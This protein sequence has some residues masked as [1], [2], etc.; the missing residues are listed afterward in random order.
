MRA[1]HPAAWLVHGCLFLVQKMQE[2]TM[3]LLGPQPIRGHAELGREFLEMEPKKPKGGA[4]FFGAE[5]TMKNNQATAERTDQPRAGLASWSFV[6]LAFAHFFAVLNDNTYRWLVTPLGYHLL[7]P[8]YRPLIL[9]LG[10]ACF[11]VSYI[12][13]VAPS[14]YLADRFSKRTV[15]AWCMTCEAAILIFG[16]VSILMSSA[17]LVF[18]ALTLM[19]AAG[20][21]MAPAF[22]GAI[23]ETVQEE[24]ISAANGALGLAN[25]LA[26]VV[27]SV[28]GN[29]LYVLA[30]PHGDSWW[31]IPGGV[32]LGFTALGWA[33]ALLVDRQP[34]ADPERGF[35]KRVFAQ[36][37]RDLK[38]LAGRRALFG[39]AAASAFLWFL[40]ATAQVNVYLFATTT[41]DI[42]QAAVGPLLGVLAIG[43]AMGSVLAAVW[44]GHRIELGL[45]PIGAGGIMVSALVLFFTPRVAAGN[46]SFAYYWSCGG[47]FLMGM[48]AGLYD[49]PLRAYLQE[50]SR[51]T[52]RGEILGAGNFLIFTAMLVA[53]GLFFVLTQLMA[54]GA[55]M[56]F[57]IAGIITVAATILIL[58]FLHRQAAE[59][60][61]KPLRRLQSL[62]GRRNF[63]REL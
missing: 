20:A 40:A 1:A 21:L 44:S 29:F 42:S 25:V 47:L 57:L 46:S 41:L 15:I 2:T 36:S 31:W 26:C 7:G 13:L 8:Q 6:G 38:L 58:Y 19:G 3:D 49:I 48:S 5:C 43:A 24:R 52:T 45:T 35:P 37:L 34:P 50:Y 28:L 33:A 10:L 51:R 9:T 60:L 62:I 61:A 53:A 18:T 63:R 12:L 54:V 11:A 4:S 27:G 39:A 55:P 59:A 30:S 23:P 16:I 14:G 22:A 17:V 56:I 32:L